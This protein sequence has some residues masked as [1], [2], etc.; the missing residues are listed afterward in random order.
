MGIGNWIT[1][2]I[3]LLHQSEHI[4]CTG[5]MTNFKMEYGRKGLNWIPLCCLKMRYEQITLTVDLPQSKDSERKGD[6]R[7]NM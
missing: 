7:L 3:Y 4:Y 6:I 5:V 1:F 2:E